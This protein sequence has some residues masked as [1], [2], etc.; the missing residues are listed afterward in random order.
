MK[1]M[2]EFLPL[3]ISNQAVLS[4]KFFWNRLWLYLFIAAQIAQ[5]DQPMLFK[6]DRQLG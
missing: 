3:Q 5:V 1:N 2:E 4:T 6:W